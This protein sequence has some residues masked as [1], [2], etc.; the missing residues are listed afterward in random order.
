MKTS[1]CLLASIGLSLASNLACASTADAVS[2]QIG[3]IRINAE[4]DGRVRFGVFVTTGSSV[5]PAGAAWY[6]SN[7]TVSEATRKAQLNTL[8]LAKKTGGTIKIW[9]TGTC[10]WA[11]VE[12]IK[13]LDMVD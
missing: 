13:D 12:T 2:S 9:G 11:G 6:A 10:D 7:A 1:V 3:S 8:M 4:S 5:C